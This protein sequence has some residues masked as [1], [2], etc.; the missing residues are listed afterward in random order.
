MTFDL[1]IDPSEKC[2]MVYPCGMTRNHPRNIHEDGILMLLLPGNL[3]LITCMGHQIPSEGEK[4][5]IQGSRK[6]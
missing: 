6:I 4:I 1:R 2:Y 3:D 5:L